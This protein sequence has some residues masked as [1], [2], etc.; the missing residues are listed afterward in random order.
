MGR[1]FTCGQRC[2]F[3]SLQT[4]KCI[5]RTVDRPSNLPSSSFHSLQTGKRITRWIKREMQ[6]SFD[7]FHSLQTGKCIS[8]KKSCTPHRTTQSCVSIPFKRESASQEEQVGRQKDPDLT[9][10]IPFKRESASQASGCEGH[11]LG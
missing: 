3:H 8:R 7:S 6:L 4:G 2:C 1:R 11:T 5:S 10:S 9:V